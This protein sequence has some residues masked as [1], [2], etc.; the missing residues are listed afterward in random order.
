MRLYIKNLQG[1]TFGVDFEADDTLRQ[2]RLRIEKSRG[3]RLEDDRWVLIHDAKILAP[4]LDKSTM[5]ELGVKDKEFMV[6]MSAARFK[7]LVTRSV[8]PKVVTP[9]QGTLKMPR[10]GD[11]LVA[12][13]GTPVVTDAEL[14]AGSG[15]GYDTAVR[16]IRSAGRPLELAFSP[17]PWPRNPRRLRFPLPLP[18]N[19]RAARRRRISR[20]ITPS[21]AA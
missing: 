10:P 7:A 19:H 9:P 2:L 8:D 11:F 15:H 6:T 13:N 16:L 14:A 20:G 1:K 5:L 21:S 12:V 4:T 17:P 3:F 18:L